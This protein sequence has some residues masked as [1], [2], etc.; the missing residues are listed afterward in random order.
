M[1]GFGESRRRLFIAV[2]LMAVL[3]AGLM[4]GTA[5]AATPQDIYNDFA[6]D[7]D[8]DGSYTQEELNAVLT[9]PVLAQYANPAVLEELKQLIRGGESRSAFPFT[10]AE[11]L[12]IL[13]G[14]VVL[15]GFGVALRKGK[16]HA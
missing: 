7:G 9:D 5:W 10:G 16:R 13:G 15:T 12:L 2:A 14:G 3:L 4:A 6:A 8:L 1:E 11:M